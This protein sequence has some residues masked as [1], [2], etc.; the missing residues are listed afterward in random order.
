MQNNWLATF[1]T[2]ISANEWYSLIFLLAGALFIYI[3]TLKII[4]PV[5]H[6]LIVK[7]PTKLDNALMDRNVFRRLV[8]LPPLLFISSYS[9]LLENYQLLINRMVTAGSIW[10]VVLSFNC[11]IL[12][13]NDI[14]EKLP[15]AKG[16]PI[17]GFIQIMQII[18]Y[19][20]GTVAAISVLMG[21]SPWVMLSGLGAMTA[22]L[23]LVFK[24]TILSLVASVRITANGLI[25]LGD[26]IE[27]PQYGADGDVVDIAL[28]S[29]QIQNWDKTITSVPTHKFIEE[30]FKNWK[31]MQ[32]AGGRRIMRN[33]VIDMSSIKFCSEEMLA[34][35]EKIDLLKDYL[36]KKKKEIGEYNRSIGIAE[37]DFTN[38]RHL[39][40]IGMFR[41]YIVEY[42]KKHPHINQKLTT[43]IRQM[44]PEA[45]GLPI[46]I[47]TFTATTVWGEYE[48]IQSDIFDHLLALVPVFDLRVFQYPSGKDLQ[49][50]NQADI[51]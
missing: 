16:K 37:D 22:V 46:Q 1:K 2:A 8:W 30:S 42:I 40:N 29:I 26:W 20:F 13:V 49:K 50:I 32:L 24:D 5:L 34:R 21:R 15:R 39:T 33:I 43:L 12:A 35:F 45:T 41:A 23:M 3:G 44:Q 14:Y 6:Y 7:S 48:N 4:L 31:G 19:L 47:Y 27:M 9:R 38:G 28:H 36:S 51:T 17:K 10:V 18:A 25:E 11:F